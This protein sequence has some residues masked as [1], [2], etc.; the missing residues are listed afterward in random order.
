VD[1]GEDSS[2]EARW[3][4]LVTDRLEETERLAPSRGAMDSAFWDRR[5]D[6][7]DAAM[8]CTRIEGDPLLRRLRR[9]TDA[10]TTVLDV[11]AGTGR[12]ALALAP[13]VRHVTAVDLSE[14]MLAVA[15]RDAT[16]AHIT[17]LETVH[18]SW[19]Q[20]AVEPA[21]IVFC[22]YVLP[23]VPDAVPFL[24][25]LDASARKRVLLYLGAWSQ[26]AVLDPL[27]RH[28]HGTPRTPGPSHLDAFDMLGE[29]GIAAQVTPVEI[30]GH[31]RFATID[32]A[33]DQFREALLLADEPDVREELGR[34]LAMWLLGRRGAYRWPLRT[35]PAAIIHWRPGQRS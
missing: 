12:F 13:G 33:V 2:A 27:W 28:F 4:R 24:E 31:R 3:R 15:R 17:N 22:A 30:V 8:K 23:L 11:G 19:V 18:A 10:S 21:D 32:E 20:A 29:L 1:R 35:M 7:Y 5:A 9:L 34:L 25:K 16:D 6:R 14:G 26:D